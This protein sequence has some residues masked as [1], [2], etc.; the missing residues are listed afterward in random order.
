MSLGEV[1]TSLRKAQI[2]FLEV[3]TNPKRALGETPTRHGKA[4]TRHREAQISHGGHNHL[5]KTSHGEAKTSH[6]KGRTSPRRSP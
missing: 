6:G 2:S 5:L 3:K 4:Q 1:Q